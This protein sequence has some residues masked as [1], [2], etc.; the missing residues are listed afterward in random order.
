MKLLFSI[1]GSI[2]VGLA[3]LGIILPLLP[4][5]P[6]LLLAAYF[7]SKSSER[8]YN[9]IINH[10]WF[11]SYIK[12]F[13]DGEGVPLNIKIYAISVLWASI[14][15]T[16]YWFT[17]KLFVQILLVSIASIITAYLIYLPT[18]KGSSETA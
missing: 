5:T 13:R 6:F 16:V 15:S 3:V 4:T 14:G 8:L 10:K 1:L 12:S 2:C 11:G 18:K 9:W 7:Y 17:D